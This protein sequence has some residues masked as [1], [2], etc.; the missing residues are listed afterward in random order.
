M[1]GE[2]ETQEAQAPAL[3]LDEMFSTGLARTLR[4]R[5]HDV[6][7][8]GES[9]ELR[10]LADAEIF[11]RAA[12]HGRRILTENVKD[13]RPLLL[14]AHE[15]GAPFAELLLTSSRAF[16]R[17]RK[18]PGPLTDALDDWLTVQA[19]TSRSIEEWLA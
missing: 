2:Q 13:F 5:G 17:S 15:S 3:L 8:V 19:T 18:N 9:P 4:G 11:T 16:P 6:V 7:A 14:R 1:T 10:A 12:S